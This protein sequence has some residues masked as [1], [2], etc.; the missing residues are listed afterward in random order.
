MP[1]R[2][3]RA[4]I[5]H[6]VTPEQLLRRHCAD[7]LASPGMDVERAC[8]QHGDT[9]V[10]AHSV[11]VTLTCA[12]LARDLQIP[13]DERAL[14]RGAL[15]HDYFLY[16]WH[17]PDPSHRLHGFRHPGFARTNALRDFQVG[18]IEQHMIARHMFPLTPLPP[19]CREAAILCVAD[20]IVASAETAR[21]IRL[22]LHRGAPLPRSGAPVPGSSAPQEGS[23]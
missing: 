8:I 20:K 9:S 1:T 23:R 15:L 18:E 6:D 19:T 22:K 10:F 3:A 13:V 11:N 4:T 7:I 14:M 21:G 2:I 16:D 5:P 12:K 17:V